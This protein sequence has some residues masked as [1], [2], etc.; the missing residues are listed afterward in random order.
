[1]ESMSVMTG[2]SKLYSFTTYDSF[3]FNYWYQIY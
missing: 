2:L 3:S 1:M